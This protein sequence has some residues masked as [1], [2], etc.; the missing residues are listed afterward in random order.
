MD[1]K[2]D[3]DESLRVPIS[4]NNV[5]C[6]HHTMIKTRFD[7]SYMRD[8]RPNYNLTTL[9]MSLNIWIYTML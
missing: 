6:G 8:S 3:V 1:D 9:N 5:L 4:H 2:D 7:Y